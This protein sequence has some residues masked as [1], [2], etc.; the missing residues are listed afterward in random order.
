MKTTFLASTSRGALDGHH[1]SL[2]VGKAEVT[3]FKHF[4]T[5]AT[6]FTLE[7]FHTADPWGYLADYLRL[8][9]LNSCS[10]RKPRQGLR[11]VI[12]YLT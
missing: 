9:G 3:S 8:G 7:L 5:S 11:T 1:Y 2:N 6:R 10:Y 12:K 4:C